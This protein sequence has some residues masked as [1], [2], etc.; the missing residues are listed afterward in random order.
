LYRYSINSKTIAK[1]HNFSDSAPNMN[2][3]TKNNKKLAVVALGGNAILRGDQ[4]GTIEEQEENTSKTIANLLFLIRDGYDLIITHGNGP[5]VGHLLLK[6]EAGN[7]LYNLPPMPLDICVAESQG[8][9][10]YMIERMLRNILTK[11]KLEKD[12]LTIVTQVVVNKNDPA[13]KNPTKRIGQAYPKKIAEKL[14]R[15]KGWVFKPS[16]KEKGSYRRVV[17]SPMPIEIF[18]RES[19]GKAAKSG[20]I[21]IASGGGGIPV[22]RDGKGMLRPVEAVIDKDFASA[23]LASRLQ[24]DELYILTDVPNVFLNFGK[25][26]QKAVEFLNYCD[27]EKYL[28]EGQFG[29]GNMLPKIKAALEFIKMGGSKSV[30]TEATKLEDRSYGTKITLEY[31]D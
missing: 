21:V 23:L 7:Q 16:P 11:N 15:E 10:G 30:I 18:N 20:A 8:D 5:Q 9:I 3:K 25:P 27:T 26:D 13:L 4:V 22:Y 29:E 31:E 12:I 2:K 14:S 1:I 6:N 24:A 19:I 28:K 17:A